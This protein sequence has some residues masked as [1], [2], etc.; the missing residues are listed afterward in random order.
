[1]AAFNLQ[2]SGLDGQVVD[3]A[4]QET[5][6]PSQLQAVCAFL[7]RDPERWSEHRRPMTGFELF[8]LAAACQ[9]YGQDHPRAQ[10]FQED[11]GGIPLG[12]THSVA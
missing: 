6:L 10:P 4:V 8:P 1:M 7:S 12:Q 9:M 2:V 3:V 11:S 5:F